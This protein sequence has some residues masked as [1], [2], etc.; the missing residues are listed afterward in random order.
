MNCHRVPGVGVACNGL[1]RRTIDK[2]L[3][4][5]CRPGRYGKSRGEHYLFDELE[6][7]LQRSFIHGWIVGLG[8]HLLSRLQENRHAE[9]VAFMREVGLRFDPA[10]MN[11]DRSDLEASLLNLRSYVGGRRDLWH[12]VLQEREISRGWVQ[13]ALETLR[14]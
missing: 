11:I 2:W 8:I 6:E 1:S 10:D 5:E 3:R 9:I 7:R 4:R 13:A 14:F 12:S